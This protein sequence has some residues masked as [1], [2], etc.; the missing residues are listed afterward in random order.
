MKNHRTR[1][2]V[3]AACLLVTI[4]VV[5]HLIYAQP[6]APPVQRVWVENPTTRPVPVAGRVGAVRQNWEYRS[7]TI[8]VGEDIEA[9][10]NRNG[11]SGWE[12]VGFTVNREFVF[13]RPSP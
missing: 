4:I 3:T 1:I 8:P 6:V 9:R 2:V 10:L 7:I 12:L 13:K 11:E 5:S